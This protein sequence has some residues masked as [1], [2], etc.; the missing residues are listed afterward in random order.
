MLTIQDQRQDL[1]QV[2]FAPE[3]PRSLM[4][5]VLE[6]HDP[7]VINYLFYSYIG[8]KRFHSKR[9]EMVPGAQVLAWADYTYWTLGY[10]ISLSGARKLV[11]AKPLEKMVAVDEFLPIMF[12]RHIK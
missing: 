11:S 4:L 6:V 9:V 2:S 7:H 3:N 12:N 1:T 10:A 5:D 8:R